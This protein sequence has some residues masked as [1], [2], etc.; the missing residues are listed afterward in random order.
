MSIVVSSPF[1]ASF[2]KRVRPKING[3][4]IYIPNY[5]QQDRHSCA[6]LAVLSVVQYFN[7]KI[8]PCEVL[9]AVQPTVENGSDRKKVEKAL[10]H[11]GTNPEFKNNLTINN[12]ITLLGY[13]VPVIITIWPKSWSYDHWTV[14]QGIDEEQQRIYLTN[15]GSVSLDTFDKEWFEYGEGLI[16]RPSA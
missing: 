12:L 9:E 2:T 13:E 5:R 14:I 10:R 7:G 11:F 16:C 15:Y 3:N 8:K 4:F 1:S 6:F